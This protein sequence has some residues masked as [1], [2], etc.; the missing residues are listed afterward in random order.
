MDNSETISLAKK[1]FLFHLKDLI[2]TYAPNFLNEFNNFEKVMLTQKN[3]VVIRQTLQ[4][5]SNK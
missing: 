2:S 5:I 1:T 4:H 3:M